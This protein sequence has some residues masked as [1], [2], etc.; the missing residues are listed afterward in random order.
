MKV[1]VL[2]EHHF[3]ELWTAMVP[4][5]E[6]CLAEGETAEM[7]TQAIVPEIEDFLKRFPQLRKVVAEHP[8]FLLTEVEV[9]L[10]EPEVTTS[11]TLSA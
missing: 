8:E 11:D 10:E 6:G 4:L 2:L 7:A 3:G 9:N 1:A 5:I